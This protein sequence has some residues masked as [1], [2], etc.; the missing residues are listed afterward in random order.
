MLYLN[1]K[2]LILPPKQDGTPY[3]L[4]DMLEYSGLDLEQLKAPVI[5]EVN[6]ES[7]AFQQELRAG[8]SVRIFEQEQR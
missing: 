2:P 8:D 1:G 4:M 7:G 3:Y 6:G 5:L